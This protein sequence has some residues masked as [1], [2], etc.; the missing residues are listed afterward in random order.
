[1]PYFEDHLNLEL[2][3]AEQVRHFDRVVID[4]YGVS[5]LTLMRRAA[6]ATVDVADELWPDLTSVAVFCGSGNNAG[7]GYIVAGLMA[8]RG[9]DVRVIVVGDP[10]KLGDDAAAARGFCET[11]RAQFVTQMTDQEL[12]VDALLGIGLSG[13]LSSQYAQVIDQINDSGKPVLAV[14]IPSGLSADTGNVSGTAIRASATVTFI[15]R[16]QGLFTGRGPALCGDIFCA[17]LDVPKEI[18]HSSNVQLLDIEGCHLTPREPDAYKNNFGHVLVVG[19]DEG[20][21]GAVMMAS[22]AALRVGAG[23]VSV[24]TR[25]NNALALTS[26]RPEV[27]ARGVTD[28]SEL[29]PLI[30][31][32]SHIVMGPGLGQSDWSRWLFDRVLQ[33]GKPGVMDADA[34]NLLSRKSVTVDDWVLTP[35]PGEAARLL[36]D[37]HENRFIAAGAIQKKFKGVTVLKGAGTLITDGRVTSVC[38]YGNPGMATAGMGDVLS[39]VIGGLLG[40][41]LSPLEAA[42]KGVVFHAY[43]GDQA[44]KQ[45]QRGMIATDV[46]P[47]IRLLVG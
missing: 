3:S 36:G 37:M 22:E 12:I 43:A 31:R 23:L 20:M 45:G 16:K 44:A 30:D 2:Y 33:A 18:F 4:E 7:D 11:T 42:Q 9:I 39:G 26:R 41:G 46:I 1:V 15:A 32:A 6:E 25:P 40:Q 34:L 21:G 24:A 28:D 29:D 5:G 17:D 10:K 19:G 47:F 35:H 38:P 27:M 13:E 14:D 8:D